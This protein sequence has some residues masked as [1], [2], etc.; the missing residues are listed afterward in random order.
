MRPEDPV[1][2]DVSG[3][4]AHLTLN[5]PDNGNLL[6]LEVARGLSEALVEVSDDSAVSTVLLTARGRMFSA[7]GDLRAMHEATDRAAFVYELATAAHEA[8]RALAHLEKPVVT[9]VQGSAAGGGLSLVL[10]SDVVVAAPDAFFVT[11]YT[12]VGLTPDCGQSW[13]LP[14]AIGTARA[15]DLMLLPRRV[16]AEEALSLGL[17]S[18][19]AEPDRLLEVAG[20]LATRLATGPAHALGQARALIRTAVGAGF[21]EH[22]DLEAETI[23]QMAATAATGDLISDFLRG[24]S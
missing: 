16:S 12:S 15:L 17:V 10:L 11:A 5:R 6:D 19:V 13:L 22:L 20:E 2:L 18:R 3:G 24:K 1:L 4:V 14:R 21:D 7:G 8:I 23:S 9:A